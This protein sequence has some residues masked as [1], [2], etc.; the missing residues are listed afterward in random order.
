MNTCPHALDFLHSLVEFDFFSSLKYL[1]WN[2]E[3]PRTFQID[4]IYISKDFHIKSKFP[5]VA[6]IRLDNP[7][8][9]NFPANNPIWGN[10]DLQIKS[11]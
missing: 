7:Y 4:E 3:Y 8:V 9:P 5:N 2:S 1:V 11:I 6:I 10:P